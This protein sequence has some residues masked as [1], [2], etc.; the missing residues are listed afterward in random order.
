MKKNF[1]LFLVLFIFLPL[2]IAQE[3]SHPF[4]GKIENIPLLA[5]G[6][7]LGLID[8]IFNPCALS[9]LFFMAAYLLS[10]GSRKK[11]ILV[12]ISYSFMVFLVYFTFI[13]LLTQ[14]ISLITKYVGYIQVMRYLV[15]GI[16][17]LL[18]LIEIKDF[19][20]EKWISLK[21]PKFA[22]PYIEKLVKAST[23]PAALTLGLLVSL[24]EIPCAGG[25]P[26][27]YASILSK[28]VSGIVLIL[29]SIFYT[30]F[31]ILPLILLTLIFYFGIA[32][33]EDA[34]KKRVGLRRY[35]RIVAGILLLIFGLSFIMGWI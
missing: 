27:V 19:F 8:G 26:F 6:L 32:K 15:G 13:Y 5:L 34:E 3:V 25:F 22:K 30:F 21:I 11:L 31:F 9:V 29:Y 23:L 14:G 28:S 12:G 16:V 10:L 35:M 33:V 1:M 4:L 17:L 20:Y 18:A 24:V 7:L 2:T